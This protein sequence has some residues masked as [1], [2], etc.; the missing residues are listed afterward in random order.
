MN[1]LK[2]PGVQ[3]AI[4]KN[5]NIEKT[6]S[7]GIANV[8][9]KINVDNDTVFNIASMTKAFTCV[10]VMQLVEQGKISLNTAVSFYIDDLPEKWQDITVYQTL[11]HTS[12]L[13]DVMN[14]RFQMIDS[15]GEEQ[16]WHAVK[17]KPLMFEPGSA[18][19][20]S[21]TNYLLA[22]KV[23]EKV[24]GQRYSDLIRGSQLKPLALHNTDAAGFAHF[25]GVYQ[26]H[27]RDY[28]IKNDG[29]LTNVLTYFPSFIR[30]GA[31]MSSTAEELARW[32]IALQKGEFFEHQSSLATLWQE[33][34]LSSNQWAKENPNM[35]PYAMGWYTVNRSLNKK[36]VTAGGGQSALAVYP[37]DGLSIVLLTNLAGAQPENLMDEL[38]EFFVDDFGLSLNTKR[39]KHKLEQQGYDKAL[40]I[41][42]AM[43]VN[44]NVVLDAVELH[45]FAELL[46]KHDK[47]EQAQ[48]IFNL[49]N[50]LFSKVTLNQEVLRQYVGNYQLADFAIKVSQNGAALFITATGD[51]TLPIFSISEQSFALKHAN[52]SINFVKDENGTVDELVLH[53]NNQTLSGKKSNRRL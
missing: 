21:Q 31:G 11:T 10:A 9:D 41:A 2:I 22:G 14:E 33:A 17:L 8:Q 13:P 47:T 1:E 20:Y 6:A 46:L 51:A 40:D 45:H 19:H 23:I 25:E 4:V 3:L 36:I 16:S 26:H 38:A 32:S 29:L 27:A 43:K 34:S 7:Y 50:H 42:S 49:N 28:R 24:S 53:L 44:Q 30:A 18:F 5:N 52:A 37:N 15:A 48:T 39:L 12:G 35:H